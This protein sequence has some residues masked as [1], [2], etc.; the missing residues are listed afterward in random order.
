MRSITHH[1]MS[2]VIINLGHGPIDIQTQTHID[3][4]THRH[5]HSDTHAHTDTHKHMHP[6]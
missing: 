6:Y 2:L 3:T 5:T 1:I 4:H